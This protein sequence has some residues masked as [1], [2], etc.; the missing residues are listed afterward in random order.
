MVN[1][2]AWSDFWADPRRTG[3]GCLPNAMK[4]IDAAQRRVWE[5]FAGGLP[6]QGK[7]L[8][9]ATGDGAVLKKMRA[10]RRDLKLFG[11]DSSP[12]L[13]PPPRGIKL[14]SAMAA[15]RLQFADS[16][17]AAVTSQ[18]GI[19]YARHPDALLEV[20]R[21]L[22]RGGR[23]RF[24]V[25]HAG[26]PVLAHNRERLKGLVWAVRES[27]LLERARALANARARTPLP[28]PPSFRDAVAEGAQRYPGQGVAEQFAL[29]VLQTLEFG[30]R[31]PTRDTLEVLAELERQ[32]NNQIGR[33]ESLAAAVQ[34]RSGIERMVATL[35]GAGVQ[36]AEP[37]EIAAGD[38]APPFAWL[39]E[40][41]KSA[42]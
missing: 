3:T 40:G 36:T 10:V 41:R 5:E 19:E 28:T 37:R 22:R 17:F 42:G 9:L 7:V 25:H 11:V 24:L 29:A 30:A 16:A 26:G 14:I 31:S 4:V 6:P 39:V 35:D 20:A 33:I 21:V 13:P 18:F 38:N 34:D 2:H 15:E 32:A 1:A 27:G 23:C 8:D 12:V